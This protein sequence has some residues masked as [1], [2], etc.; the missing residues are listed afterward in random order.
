MRYASDMIFY[1][2]GSKV[3]PTRDS[4]VRSINATDSST[5]SLGDAMVIIG[6][7]IGAIVGQQLF[8]PSDE[9]RYT[10]AFLAILLL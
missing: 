3:G 7:K 5:R 4:P 1:Q 2:T 6:S 10:R 9:T 8:Q